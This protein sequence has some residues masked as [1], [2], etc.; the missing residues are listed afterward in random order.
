MDDDARGRNFLPKN[1]TSAYCSSDLMHRLANKVVHLPGSNNWL[2]DVIEKQR[3]REDVHHRHETGSLIMEIAGSK[4]SFYSNVFYYNLYKF[5][6]T[7][8]ICYL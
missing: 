6:F 2:R 4:M 1:V 7:S 5:V 3:R 8:I